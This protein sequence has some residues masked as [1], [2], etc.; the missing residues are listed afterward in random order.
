MENTNKNTTKRMMDFM[1]SKYSFRY[2]TLT[3]CVEYRV[4]TSA[5]TRYTPLDPRSRNR[6][7]LEVQLDGINASIRDVRNYLESDYI[8]TYNPIEDYLNSCEGTWDGNDHITDLAKTVPTNAPLWTAW[9]RTWILAMVAQWQHTDGRMYGNSVAPLLI[10]PQGYNKS[11]FCRQLLPQ[12]LAWGYTDSL[13]LSEHRQVMLAMSQQLLINLDEFN[14]ISPRVQQGFLKN[15]I[16][17]PN[18]RIKR[19]Y[20]THVEEVPR[21]ASFIATSNMDDILTDPSGN[22]RFIGIELT[23][24]IDVSMRPNYQQLFAQAE[25]AIWNGEKTYFDA[26]QTALIMENNKQYQ[27]VEPIMQCFSECFAPTEDESEGNYMT[28]AAIYGELKAK[29]GASLEAKSLLS[30]GRS[31]KNMD[32]LKRKRTMKG[33]EYLVVKIK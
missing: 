21:T 22:R 20:A 6:I 4:N 7:T 31:L 14:Q 29:Y 2:N 28:A 10:S 30:F 5:D 18:I 16:Q 11:T 33:T 24:P 17:L 19:P 23:G 3:G 15:V 8:R 1:S 25:A 12:E 32:G 13:A 26:E 9:F 27:R